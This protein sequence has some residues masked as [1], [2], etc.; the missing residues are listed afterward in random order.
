MK[1]TSKK[2]VV[3]DSSSSFDERPEDYEDVTLSQQEVNNEVSKILESSSEAE[4][5][6]L[7]SSSEEPHYDVPTAKQLEIEAEFE[8]RQVA[9]DAKMQEQKEKMKEHPTQGKK[10]N[11][12][13]Q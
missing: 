5:S 8:K 10:G 2:V 12:N 1:P 4:S 7:S 11:H 6:V 9:H 13:H 3:G